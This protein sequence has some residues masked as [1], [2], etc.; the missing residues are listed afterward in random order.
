MEVHRRRR[1]VVSLPEQKVRNFLRKHYNLSRIE[2]FLLPLPENLSMALM[3]VQLHH[4]PCLLNLFND[5]KGKC[6]NK[7]AREFVWLYLFNFFQNGWLPTKLSAQ[8]R[9]L[10]GNF[11]RV[12]GQIK[13]CVLWNFI[14][15]PEHTKQHV[16]RPP[17]LKEKG[18]H[19][20]HRSSHN[21]STVVDPFI[22]SV[23]KLEQRITT[24]GS[25]TQ[26]SQ[27]H[28]LID[29]KRTSGPP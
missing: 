24:G 5:L 29:R 21:P 19:I 26:P 14:C 20:R 18:I 16:L 2:W 12:R 27:T 28:T 25:G 4:S 9:L 3:T 17:E 11:P 7:T 6:R 23:E 1:M 10:S 13:Y 8:D 15:S 22:H